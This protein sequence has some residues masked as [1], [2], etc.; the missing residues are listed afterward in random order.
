MNQAVGNGFGIVGAGYYLPEAVRTNDWWPRDWIDEHLREM[1]ADVVGALNQA[2][3]D[4][5]SDVDPEIVE[6]VQRYASDPFRGAVERHV[7]DDGE[8]SSDLEVRA[9]RA[10]LRDAGMSAADIDLLITFSQVPDFPCPGNHALVA[11][12]L[13]MR[14]DATSMTIGTDCASFIAHLSVASQLLAVGGYRAALIVQSNASTR[15]MNWRRPAS[16]TVGDGAT[17]F[18]LAPV[19]SGL[20]FVAS[21]SMTLGQYH[22]TVR[23]APLETPHTPWYAGEVH[24]SRLVFQSMDPASTR[25]STIS[26]VDACRAVCTPLLE[27]ARCLPTDVSLFVASQPSAWFPFACAMGLGI[28]PTST[29]CT[30]PKYGHLMPASSAINLIS[31]KEQG[32][33]SRGDVVLIYSPGAGLIQSAALLRWV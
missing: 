6:Y 11:H 20:G 12:K 31:A 5:P 33:L 4:T 9:A 14:T 7:I 17:A 10:A 32:R 30:Y 22:K 18:V 19:M 27:Q 21:N 3:A 2:V 1:G 16:I 8:T 23:V 26:I 13:G 25:E 28:P 29:L 15:L 24:K